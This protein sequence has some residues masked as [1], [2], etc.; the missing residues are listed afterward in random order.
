MRE[1][2]SEGNTLPRE[3]TGRPL[4]SRQNTKGEFSSLGLLEL[5]VLFVANRLRPES[6]RL[7]LKEGDLG[8]YITQTNGLREQI[9]EFGAIRLDD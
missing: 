5:K 4:V 1:C 8:G 3:Q 2:V 6:S 9:G 7:P